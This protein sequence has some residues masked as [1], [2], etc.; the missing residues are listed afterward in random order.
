LVLTKGSAFSILSIAAIMKRRRESA[1]M[2]AR[3]RHNRHS[4]PD[5]LWQEIGCLLAE[6]YPSFENLAACSK[7]HRRVL[8]EDAPKKLAKR[9]RK[10]HRAWRNVIF[11]CECDIQQPCTCGLKSVP[12]GMRTEALCLEAVR[13]DWKSIE[14]VPED[15]ETYEIR[16]AAA[17]Q[18]LA[19]FQDLS[20]VV[21]L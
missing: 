8:K 12:H 5:E 2:P 11:P 10:W 6:D 16:N 3:T 19:C 4:L 7:K 21:F 14:Y 1:A 9:R 17:D 18:K 20:S 13:R 15:V